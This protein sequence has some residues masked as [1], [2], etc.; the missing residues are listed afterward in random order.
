MDRIDK[1]IESIYKYWT[2]VCDFEVLMKVSCVS[3]FV[4][5]I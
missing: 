3:V 4:A 1:W 5:N 2:F